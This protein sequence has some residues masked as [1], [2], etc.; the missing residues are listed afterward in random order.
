MN[1]YSEKT[2]NI[3]KV[4]FDENLVGISLSGIN[5]ASVLS[6][7]FQLPDEDSDET[8]D[9]FTGGLF[10]EGCTGYHVEDNFF[11]GMLG[12]FGT[13]GKGYGISIKNSG[14]DNN[15]IYNNEFYRV[16]TGICV[17]GENRGER[18]SS[19]LC[20][21]CNEMSFD[22]ND[23]IV[24]EDDGPLTGMQGIRLYQGN[25]NDTISSTAPAGN[26]FTNFGTTPA[27]YNKLEKFN[28]YNV[29]EDF[30]YMHHLIEEEIVAPLDSNYTGT[31]IT[32]LPTQIQYNKSGACP[33]GLGGGQLKSFTN[34]RETISEADNQIPI[35]FNQINSLIDGGNTEGLNFEVLTSMPDEALE[36][37]QELLADSPYLSDTVIKQAIYKED[38]LP[39]AMIR[40]I[41]AANPQSAK[42]ND[43]LEAL[44]G[45][46]DPMP[47]YMMAHIMEGR[48]YFGAKELLEAGIQSWQQLRSK[49]KNELMRHFLLDTSFVNS[50][51]SVIALL[52]IENDLSSKYGLAFAYWNKEDSVNA[53]QTLNNIPIQFT[54]SDNQTIVHQ[55]YGEYFDILQQLADSNWRA[56]DLDS[57]S[58]QSLFNILAEGNA[59]IIAHARGLLVK[60]G[61]LN[62]METV[63]L[64]SYSKSRPIVY[65]SKE[66]V[67]EQPKSE[68]LKLFP[69]PSG[70]YV[71][72]Y[73]DINSDYMAASIIIYDMKGNMLRKYLLKA[74]ENQIVLNLS[75]L[76]NGIFLIALQ[77]DRQ[78]LDAKKLSKGRN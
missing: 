52:E 8:G 9:R 47:D 41:M 16:Q 21:K 71:I 67:S 1:S 43:L 17:M 20:L 73:Y 37:S 38:V 66:K 22:I 77:V 59:D 56:C 36:L 61:F 28:Y 35:L 70:D 46:Y 60:G 27:D 55:Q 7:D 64:P 26:T 78:M 65:Y 57:A 23:F 44:D 45:R 2:L 53:W 39:N 42:K 68:N 15:E 62:Y 12:E 32:L 10:M 6:N 29:A 63:N 75:D 76:P 74:E 72:A 19:G 18:E 3:S 31:T 5:Y 24:V 30:W 13:L 11:H 69:N 58:V 54:L 33:S 51:D 4:K 14:P 40:D 48:E 50:L 25:P 49:A 34:P